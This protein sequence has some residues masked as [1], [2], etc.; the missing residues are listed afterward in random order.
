MGV[1]PVMTTPE[2]VPRF[3]EISG[4]DYTKPLVRV[5]RRRLRRAGERPTKERDYLSWPRP[6]GSTSASPAHDMAY[7]DRGTPSWTPERWLQHA[8]EMLELPG[9]P[10]DYHF[11]LQSILAELW[12]LR[13]GRPK[14]YKFI[15]QVALLNHQLLQAR[16]AIVRLYLSP[17][18]PDRI[19]G[20]S[21]YPHLIRLYE[22]EGA[23]AEA[24]AMVEAWSRLGG[25]VPKREADR[26][27]LAD[28]LV[29][30]SGDTPQPDVTPQP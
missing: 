30:L 23:I 6:D 4:V 8:A 14:V 22:R 7:S 12:R 28:R 16:P 11:G 29:Q 18:E 9:E 19:L 13:F 5:D 25:N 26:H 21:C 27:R 1:L 15:E 17:E 24:T 3:A 10:S 20:V 2:W